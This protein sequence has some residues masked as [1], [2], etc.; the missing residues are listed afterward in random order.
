MKQEFD[1]LVG[2]ETTGSEYF[3]IEKEYMSTD[4]DKVKFAANWKKNDGINR[5]ARMRVRKIEELEDL[6][7][8]KNQQMEKLNKKISRLEQADV[9]DYECS[10]HWKAKYEELAAKVNEVAELVNFLINCSAVPEEVQ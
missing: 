3:E 4:I 2:F 9:Q 10:H 7:T 1:K 6:I 8:A 5:L